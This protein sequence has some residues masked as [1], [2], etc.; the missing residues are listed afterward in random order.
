MVHG[1]ETLIN[2]S[3]YK[4]AVFLNQLKIRSKEVT[5]FL[6]GTTKPKYGCRNI[7]YGLVETGVNLDFM[8]HERRRQAGVSGQGSWRMER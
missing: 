6:V 3:P 1:I 2:H 5:N 8:L 4:N 7:K